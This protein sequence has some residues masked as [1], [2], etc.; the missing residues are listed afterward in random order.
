MNDFELAKNYFLEGVSLLESGLYSDAENKFISS[1]KLIPE[2]VSTLTNLSVTQLKL[3][4]YDEAKASA[5]KAILLESGNSE[6]YLN[7]GLI[8]KELRNP[9][10]AIKHFN[11][12]ISL[13]GNYCEAWYNK[14]NVFNEL[15]RYNEAIFNY[16]KALSLKLDYAE[17]WSNKG[18]A[19]NELKQYDEAIAH[20][21]R[22]LTINSEIDFVRGELLHT[23]MKM[24]SWDHFQDEVNV[25]G[26]NIL[27]G[28]KVSHPF[29]LL[30]LVDD[31][32]LH[33]TCS[34]MEA[35]NKYA[36]NPALGLIHKASKK[37]KIS[38]GYFSA[39]FTHHAVAILTAELFE[40]HNKDQFEIIAFSFGPDDKSPMRKR[41]MNSFNRFIDVSKI[42][43]LEVA[44][45]SREFRVDIAVDLGGYTG[46]SRTNIFSY[47]AAPIQVSY[48]GYLSTMGTSYIDYILA[49]K[50]IIPEGSQKFYDEKVVYLP[51]YQVNDR[52]RIISEKVF[53]KQELGLPE[54]KFVFCCFNNNY[55]VLPETFHSWV[56]ILK[57]VD[58]SVLYLYAANRWV[59]EN[60]R[61]QI[62]I[63]G[64]SSSRLV[65]GG[66][67]PAEEYLARYRACDLFL[68]TFPYNAGTTGSDA[69]WAGLP[70]LT[71]T[72][73][74]FA[75][76]VAASLLNAIGLTEL[77]TDSQQDYEALA[78]ELATNPKKLQDIKLRLANNRLTAPLF[79]T[80]LFTKNLEA[81]YV[82]MYE[83]YQIDL[84]PE[85]II[86]STSV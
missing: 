45:L 75:S 15:K 28:K 54:N 33:K 44:R 76:R 51:S 6:A 62:E 1:L 71:R 9:E 2:R 3:K 30:S 77:V 14:G 67:L 52:K 19:L 23:K 65:F 41:L 36:F 37:E 27:A 22:A 46:G 16:D 60:L 35:K 78:I 80:P 26:N 17:C 85:N 50:T 24:C 86:I 47:K 84:L 57:A 56:K 74:S 21:E 8:E 58:D 49:D 18:I 81:A 55:K 73:Q 69:L 72:G 25:V 42:S 83:R 38:I 63:R 68:D 7:L 79:N 32:T 13:N 53:T 70:V 66:N 31:P 5:E 61:K 82:R 34:E 4:K 10:K 48:I 12:A 39:D 20:Y 29:H 59:E 43:D 64:V 11:K 40:L